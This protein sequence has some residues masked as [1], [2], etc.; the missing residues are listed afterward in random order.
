MTKVRKA[1]IPAAGLGT[2]FL[3]ATKAMAKEMMPIVDTPSIQYVVEE[4]I[5]SGI[6][7][8]VIISGKGKSPIEDHFD[9]NFALE[10]NLREKGKTAMLDMVQKTNIPHIHYVRQAYPMDWVT[11]FCR[12][13]LSSE[14]NLL[15][16]CWATISCR[17]KSR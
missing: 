1:V 16:Y 5:A 4:A 8:I 6:E 9:A 14:T 15:L 10:Q 2:R 3:P 12:R 17:A 11:P 7:E 13:K